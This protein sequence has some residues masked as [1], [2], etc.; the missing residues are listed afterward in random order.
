MNAIEKAK[1]EVANLQLELTQLREKKKELE[2]QAKDADQRIRQLVGFY[3][4]R[5]L[6]GQAERRVKTAEREARDAVGRLVVWI[7]P[8]WRIGKDDKPYIV[9][10]VTPKRIYVRRQ[11][12]ERADFYEKDGTTG[13]RYG[14]SQIDVA[15][16]F[17]E[18]LDAYQ[19]ANK[20]TS[21]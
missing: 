1:Q 12:N 2:Q 10:K 7:T 17:P 5:G 21:R 9:D 15:K 14:D 13:T 4:S 20:R 16:T 6:I 19:K 18:G 3:S 8:P 11:G